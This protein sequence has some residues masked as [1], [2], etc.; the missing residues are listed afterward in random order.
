[1]N[2]LKNSEVTKMTK[3]CELCNKE[4][5]TKII[6]KFAQIVAYAKYNKR[7]KSNKVVLQHKKPKNVVY[8]PRIIVQID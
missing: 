5:E 3:Y 8:L 1:M 2:L 4:V 6:F 7:N